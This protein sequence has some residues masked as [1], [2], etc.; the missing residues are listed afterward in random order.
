MRLITWTLGIFKKKHRIT[1]VPYTKNMNLVVG[2]LLGGFAAILQSAGL[3]G[4]IGYALSIMATGPIILATVLSIRIGLLTYAVTTLLLIILQPS[5]VLIFLFTT[6]LLGIALGI[7]FKFYK[8]GS[9]VSV[10]GG[11]SLSFGIL[12]LLYIFQFPVLGPSISRQ[13]SG[14]VIAGVFLFS[15]FYSWIWMNL[16]IVGMKHLNKVMLRKIW[17]EKD[18]S[19]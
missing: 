11:T 10:M 12:I 5:E 9:M 3:I 6:G 19:S 15:Q 13:V 16:S 8:T 4:G 18:E 2:S 17:V 1:A 14:T 7:G